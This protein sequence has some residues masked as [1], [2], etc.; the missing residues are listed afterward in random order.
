L[1][2]GIVLCQ[3]E[4]ILMTAQDWLEGTLYLTVWWDGADDYDLHASVAAR[5]IRKNPG[6][7]PRE[8]DVAPL[9]AYRRRLA[10]A[11]ARVREHGQDGGQDDDQNA[12][13]QVD[14]TDLV[15]VGLACVLEDEVGCAVGLLRTWSVPITVAVVELAALGGWVPRTESA[16]RDN[17]LGQGLSKEDLLVLS[18]GAA[19]PEVNPDDIDRDEILSE[20]ATQLSGKVK[21][22]R[23]RIPV[24]RGSGSN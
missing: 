5:S 3:P 20:Y 19:T 12:V 18:Y 1:L 24:T 14:S 4:E 2:Y 15:Q 9:A 16:G 22:R 6:P 8:V 21:V 23:W 10:D 17:A 13:F 7:R 11:F